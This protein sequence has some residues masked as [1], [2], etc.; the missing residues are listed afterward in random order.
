MKKKIFFAGIVLCACLLTACT[1]GANAP[2]SS[3]PQDSALSENG[4]VPQQSENGTTA[5]PDPV[6]PEVPSNYAIC[7]DKSPAEVEAFAAQVRQHILNRDWDALSEELV[8]EIRIGGV[9]YSSAEEFAAADFDA[10]IDDDFLAAIEAERCKNMFCNAN[11]IAM[12][13]G[14]VWIAE[15]LD[16]DGNSEGLK[17]IAINV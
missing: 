15:V 6:D 13:D 8:Y 12:G 2:E 4:N 11:G 1:Q 5:D 16:I 10:V 7:T 9:L 17:V 14:Q 3:G